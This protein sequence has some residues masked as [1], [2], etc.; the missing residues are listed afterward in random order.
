MFILDDK[1]YRNLEEQVQK[2]KEDIAYHYEVT[3][4]LANYGIEVL[5]MVETYEEIADIDEGERY[6]QAYL[7]GTPEFSEVYIWT[8]ANPNI[9]HET[10][11]WLNIGP[12]QAAGIQGP[13]GVGIA[14]AFVNDSYQLVLN[15]TNG[16]SL[17]LGKSIRGERG[18]K[19]ATG[20]PGATGPQGPKG[21]KGDKGDRGPTGPQGPTGSLNIINT[22]NSL[23]EVPSA[24]DYN[25]GDAFLLKQGDLTTLYVLTGDK[26]VTSSYT[27]QETSFGGGTIVTVGGRQQS[28]WDSDTKVS[29]MVPS[30]LQ[31]A[32]V[33]VD[34]YSDVLVPIT[35]ELGVETIVRRDHNNR[36]KASAPNATNDVANKF[37]V[38]TRYSTLD[39]KIESL[40]QQVDNLP[41]G[42]SGGGASGWTTAYIGS[43]QSLWLNMDNSKR[44]EVMLI[45]KHGVGDNVMSSSAFLLPS[46]D[47][48]MSAVTNLKIPVLASYYQDGTCYW[49][50]SYDPPS[51]QY[52]VN[53]YYNGDMSTIHDITC[54]YRE[55]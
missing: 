43:G 17:V 30:G 9:G 32:Y 15:L 29:K 48:Q 38:D 12:M 41:T 2:N 19:G 1:E 47:D 37:Y 16:E 44:Y 50:I 20:S 54:Y 10:A 33:S 36:F 13:I 25:L 26:D 52:Y 24:I 21:P 39:D 6:G 18:E 34:P 27:W 11:Y 35:S 14:G 46:G 31:S 55:V 42:G 28:T 3:R 45:S 22:F 53:F 7:V 40:Q 51:S 8:R 4:V 49:D 23:S 5:G